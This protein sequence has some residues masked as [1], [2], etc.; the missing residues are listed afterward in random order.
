LKN[1][2]LLAL[3]DSMTSWQTMDFFDSL[4]LCREDCHITLL[5]VYRKPSASEQLMGKKFTEKE[6]S[7]LLAFLQRARD[8]LVENGYNPQNIKIELVIDAYLTVAD[9]IIDQFKKGDFNMVVIGRRKMS[10]SEEFVLG[11]ASAK[12][13]RAIEGAAVL[14]VKPK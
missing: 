5:H 7:R 14:V 2:I 3:K 12:L 10:K 13:C 4:S 1:S 11:D 6:R 9:G 8:K